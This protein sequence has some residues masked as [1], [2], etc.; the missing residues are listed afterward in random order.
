MIIIIAAASV[1]SGAPTAAISI[2][3]SPPGGLG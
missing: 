2:K 1:V 3:S